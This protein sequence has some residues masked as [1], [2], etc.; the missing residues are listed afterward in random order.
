MHRLCVALL[1]LC[2]LGSHPAAAGGA[3][4]LVADVASM[5]NDDIHWDGSY[6]GL[7]PEAVTDRAKRIQAAGK[8]AIPLLRDTLRDPRKYVAAHVLL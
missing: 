6:F 1:A 8:T 4:T 2:L 5:T 7:W 3:P